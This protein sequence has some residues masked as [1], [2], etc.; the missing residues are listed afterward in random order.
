MEPWRDAAA[1]GMMPMDDGFLCVVLF[2]SFGVELVKKRCALRLE[3]KE[4]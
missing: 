4:A 3:V 2:F 1:V